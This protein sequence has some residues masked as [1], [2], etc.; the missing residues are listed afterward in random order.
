MFVFTEGPEVFLAIL[1][2]HSYIM[3]ILGVKDRSTPDIDTA[4]GNYVIA[5]TE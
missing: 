2:C 4:K 5:E 1:Y 3:N